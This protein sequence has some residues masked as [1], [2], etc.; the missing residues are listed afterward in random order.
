M[1]NKILHLAFV[2][3]KLEQVLPAWEVVLGAQAEIFGNKVARKAIVKSHDAE[4]VF[5]EPNI[6]KDSYWTR[7]LRRHGPGLDHIAISRL[8]LDAACEE[9]TKCG[10][11]LRHQVPLEDPTSGH[12]IN[13]IER[14]SLKVAVVELIEDVQQTRS[15]KR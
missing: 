12:R 6:A 9:I 3:E 7:V 10:M 1:R 5:M 2:V 15:T 13:F 4:F 8:N 14:E 11:L